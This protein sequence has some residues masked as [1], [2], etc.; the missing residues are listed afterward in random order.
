MN[1]ANRLIPNRFMK[2]AYTKKIST[3][4]ISDMPSA[5]GNQNLL[6][7]KGNTRNIGSVGNTY[8]KV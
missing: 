7:R 4:T 5:I 6:I 1:Y 8:Q 2:K 3:V